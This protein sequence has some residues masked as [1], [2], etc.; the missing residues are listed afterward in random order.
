MIDPVQ[1][2][3][4]QPDEPVDEALLLSW[5]AR[6]LA[7]L[8][9]IEWELPPETFR[10]ARSDTALQILYERAQLSGVLPEDIDIDTLRQIVDRFV[11]NFRA[12]LDH[13][14]ESYP[15]RVEVFRAADGGASAVT[16]KAWLALCTGE[17]GSVDIPG[18]H[19]TVVQAP[20]VSTL[21]SRLL[22]VLQAPR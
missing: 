15:G 9:G 21:A 17:A 6:D 18:N 11:R 16:T 7:G 5:F 12:L 2:P 3:D 10:S 8:S 20:R 4:G 1:P 14:P 13:S 22:A 19:Y